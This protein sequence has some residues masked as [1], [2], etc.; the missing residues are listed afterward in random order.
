MKLAIM[1]PYLL[2]YIGYFQLIKATDRFVV[3]DDVNFI[4]KGWINRNNILVSG[5]PNLFTVPLI[6][7][8]QNKLIYEVGIS[9]EPWQK[10]L[11]RT[12]QQSYQK[13]PFYSAVFPILEKIITYPAQNISEL[14][15]FSITEIIEYLGIETEVIPSSKIYKNEDLKSQNRILDI[16]KK[17][18]ATTY[19]NP[20][21]GMELYDKVL[22]KDNG[23]DL[24]FIK[25]KPIQYPQ[26]Q[27]DFVPWLS[28]VDVLMH[29]SP[30]ATNEF[31]DSYELI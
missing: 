18:G 28:I 10:K 26:F 31:L 7:A 23:I 4:N 13:A 22:F 17:E 25:S 19:I 27:N 15:T 2:P 30:S 5:K 29:N 12:L 1:Q 3:Y 24:F 20:I 11:L 9:N 6:N 16:V 21:G 14:A 8:S